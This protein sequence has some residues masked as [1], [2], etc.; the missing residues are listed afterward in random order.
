MAPVL[1]DLLEPPVLD[2]EESRKLVAADEEQLAC[3]AEG[4]VHAAALDDDLGEFDETVA[5]EGPELHDVVHPGGCHAD[6]VW[7]ELDLVDLLG[8]GLY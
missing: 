4:Q 7:R 8:V 2:V 3:R 5:L 6:P 1:L